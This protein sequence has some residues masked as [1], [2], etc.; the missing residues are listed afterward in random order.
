MLDLNGE[1]S[2]GT[3]SLTRD[4]VRKY[5]YVLP[6][7]MRFDNASCLGTLVFTDRSGG[8][9]V[10]PLDGE[11][12]SDLS[13]MTWLLDP[14]TVNT[15]PA[16]ANFEVFINVDG[17]DYKV[18]YGRVIRREVSFPLNPVGPQ[19]VSPPLMYEDQ[20]QRSQVGP[21]W[22]AKKGRISMHKPVGDPEYALAGKNAVSAAALWYAP[23]QSDTVEM[24]VGLC[25]GGAGTTVIVLSSNYAM[26]SFMGVRFHEPGILGAGDIKIVSGQ[27]PTSLTIQ[28]SPYTNVTIP[29]DGAFYTI[30]YSLPLN[31]LS[32][33]S[34]SD[35]ST[36][37]LQ[38]EDTSGL[39]R[40]GAGYRYSGATFN[41]TLLTTG[42][43]LYY[44]KV[45]DVV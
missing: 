42:P 19:S 22:I 1:P 15:I 36:P 33:Y 31:T 21:R 25:G 29:N 6:A 45:K 17:Y 7:G 5:T 8:Q 34:G 2:L 13:S 32:V 38:W 37:I 40:H 26:T 16:G 39:V 20:L 3:L 27:S 35:I 24:T 43:L 12:S 9:Y 4:G 30:R 44:W 11:I 28:G 41:G 23:T 18:R 10:E 14:E